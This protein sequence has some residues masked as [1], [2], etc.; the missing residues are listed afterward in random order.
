MLMQ[1]CGKIWKPRRKI[2]A[3]TSNGRKR[4]KKLMVIIVKFLKLKLYKKAIDTQRKEK[5]Y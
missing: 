3:S 1:T 5:T 2:E 4:G